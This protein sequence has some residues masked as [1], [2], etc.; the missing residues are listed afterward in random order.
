MSVTLR[1]KGFEPLTYNTHQAILEYLD[2]LDPR[3]V[4]YSIID[5]EGKALE[6][7]NDPELKHEPEVVQIENLEDILNE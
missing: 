7:G 4:Y 2:S 3:P 6:G 5:N 1:I